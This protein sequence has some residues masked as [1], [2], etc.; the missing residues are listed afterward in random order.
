MSNCKTPRSRRYLAWIRSQAC[1]VTGKRIGVQ[2]AHVRWLSNAGTGIKPSDFWTL[3]LHADEH[4]RQHE[5]GEKSYWS[6]L[7]INPHEA[8]IGLL[9]E[10]I[11]NPRLVILALERTII[12]ED[13]K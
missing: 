3:P 5:H 12:E 10:Y 8:I 4:R 13:L 11:D 1:L 2:A 7:G 9:M 6:S